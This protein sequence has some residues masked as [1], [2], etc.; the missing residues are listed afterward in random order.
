MK[1]SIIDV[2]KAYFGVVLGQIIF[3]VLALAGLLTVFYV[4]SLFK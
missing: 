1:F 3:V 2:I 4:L